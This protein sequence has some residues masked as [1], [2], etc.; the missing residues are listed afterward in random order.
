MTIVQLADY[1]VDAR[2]TQLFRENPPVFGQ[3][4]VNPVTGGGYGP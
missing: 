1:K 2:V 4:C 3:Y